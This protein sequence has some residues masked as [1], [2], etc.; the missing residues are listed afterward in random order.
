MCRS[1]CASHQKTQSSREMQQCPPHT[2]Q[3]HQPSINEVVHVPSHSWNCWEPLHPPGRDRSC[4]S[5][6]KEHN[7]HN[8]TLK[9]DEYSA[10]FYD[11]NLDSFTPCPL[12]QCFNVNGTSYCFQFEWKALASDAVRESEFSCNA[13]SSA[14]VQRIKDKLSSLRRA[15]KKRCRWSQSIPSA[16]PKH[17]NGFNSEWGVSWE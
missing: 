10:I 5:L 3:I 1:K 7:R 17:Q 15:K 16:K 11:D 6:S 9:Q 2:N 4:L 12:T 8:F 13:A 14:Y